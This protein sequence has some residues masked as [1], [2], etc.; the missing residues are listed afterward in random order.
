MPKSSREKSEETRGRIVEAAYR[1]FLRQGFHGTSIREISEQAGLSVGAIYNHFNTK[2]DIWVEVLENKHPYRQVLP[3]LNQALQQSET[4]S[5]VTLA[6][7]GLVQELHQRPDLFNLMFI[8]FVEFNSSHIP[9][10]IEEII[11]HMQKLL[12]VL[13]PQLAH[14]RQMPP[15][16]IFRAF[17]GFFFSYYV[18]AKIMDDSKSAV[19]DDPALDQFIE[20]FLYGVLPDNDPSRSFHPEKSS[21][22]L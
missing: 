7:R 21:S 6:A 2:E 13:Q 18:T 4:P 14:F 8:E 5:A 16:L 1:L 11:P 12:P 22:Q 15:I 9:H 10:V 3:I 17:M 20:L 19:P